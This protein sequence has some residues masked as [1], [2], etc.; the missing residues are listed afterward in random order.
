MTTTNP[1]FREHETGSFQRA[2]PDLGD[3]DGT[4]E[5][6]TLRTAEDHQH[7]GEKRCTD[8]VHL[9][10]IDKIKTDRTSEKLRLPNLEIGQLF[11]SMLQK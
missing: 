10:L 8:D 2:R 11:L 9:R 7:Q 1:T 4:K 6:P 5:M 3:T